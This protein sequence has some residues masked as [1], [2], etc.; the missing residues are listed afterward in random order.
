MSDISTDTEDI[1]K[2]MK[3][4][5]PPGRR[6]SSTEIPDSELLRVHALRLAEVF[7]EVRSESGRRGKR[8]AD[9]ESRALPV[10]ICRMLDE[11]IKIADGPMDATSD[12]RKT[13]AALDHAAGTAVMRWWRTRKNEKEI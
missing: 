11:Y 13:V 3:P 6:Y 2:R 5:E 8:I 9:L 12:V 1:A 10:E 7:R 4:W